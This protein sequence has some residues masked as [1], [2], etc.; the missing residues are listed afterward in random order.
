VKSKGEILSKRDNGVETV[1]IVVN[2]TQP[3]ISTDIKQ[4]EAK[5][6][7]VVDASTSFQMDGINSNN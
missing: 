2:N 7:K 4:N 3:T 1:A 6:E 5:T